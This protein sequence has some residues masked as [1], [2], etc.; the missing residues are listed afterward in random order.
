MRIACPISGVIVVLRQLNILWDLQVFLLR[1][2]IVVG[3]VVVVVVVV[4]IAVVITPV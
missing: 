1:L 4:V 2:C 3:G